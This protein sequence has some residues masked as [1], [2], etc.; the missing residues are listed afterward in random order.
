MGLAMEYGETGPYKVIRESFKNPLSNDDVTVFLPDKAKIPMPV[1][2]FAHGLGGNYYQAYKSLLTHVASQGVAVVFSPY[3]TGSSWT[4]QYDILWRGFEKAATDYRYEFDLDRVGFFGHSWGGGATSNMALRGLELGWGQDGLLMFM[5]APAPANGVTDED[6]E[7]ITD[8][9]L[10]MQVY[11]NDT[12]APHRI[13]EDIYATIG[14]PYENKAYYFVQGAEHSEP[15]ERVV[16]DYDRLAIWTPLD[17]LM[18][19]TFGIDNPSAG[20]AYALDGEGDH[21]KTIIEADPAD[22][23]DDGGSGGSGWLDWLDRFR[24]R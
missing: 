2:F 13:A 14:I 19:Y 5:M 7:S 24:N 21:Y 3:P 8:A 9:N 11:E 20:K 23:G 22:G 10:I 15:S 18:D 12:N 1:M 17:A 6:L 4:Q 16:D